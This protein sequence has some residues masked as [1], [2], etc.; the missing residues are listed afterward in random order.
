MT[1]EMK[2]QRKHLFKTILLGSQFKTCQEPETFNFIL[3][4]KEITFYSLRVE[5]E[6]IR[7]RSADVFIGR[8]FEKGSSFK[9]KRKCWIDMIIPNN[10]SKHGSF[11]F[12]W[13][14]LSFQKY[15]YF[16]NGIYWIGKKIWNFSVISVQQIL[17]CA[18]YLRI[19]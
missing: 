3:M 17:V 13:S 6:P 2:W 15:L 14:L 1:D 12:I 8:L 4:F 7:V 9:S 18:R 5:D 16:E 11:V 19:L 10:E